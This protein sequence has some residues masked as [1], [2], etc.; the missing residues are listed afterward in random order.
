MFY[1]VRKNKGSYFVYIILKEILF[2]KNGIS[3]V[4]ILKERL[5]IEVIFYMIYKFYEIRFIFLIWFILIKI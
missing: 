4:I 2:L 5:F 3:G 1:F